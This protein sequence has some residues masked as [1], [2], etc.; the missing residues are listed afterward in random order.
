MSGMRG[1]LERRRALGLCALLAVLAVALLG[2]PAV[3]ESIFAPLRVIW[4]G[5]TALFGFLGHAL[6]DAGAG[7]AVISRRLSGYFVFE[8]RP[9]GLFALILF[10]IAL[11]MLRRLIA[12]YHTRARAIEQS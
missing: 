1:G 12:G 7:L 2:G 6:Y 4:K 11:F 3:R 8:S 5:A 10:V 9:F